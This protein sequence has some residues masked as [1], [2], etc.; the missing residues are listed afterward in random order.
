MKRVFLIRHAKSSWKDLSL[1]DI[2][3]PLNKRGLRDAPFM[4]KLLRGRNVHAD[5]IISSSAKRALETATYFADALNIP[6]EEIEIRR[7]IYDAYPDGILEQIRGFRNDWS[8]VLLF[9]HNP[10]F[11]SFVNQ[12]T[13][14]YIANIP[15]CGIVHLEAD[16]DN[17]TEFDR[18]SASLVAFYYPKQYFN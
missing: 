16:I 3:R 18:Q 17:W 12:F 11:T 13:E 6:K 5:K 4:A 15:T 1:D 14:E 9:G 2:D 8:S 7:A 10:T